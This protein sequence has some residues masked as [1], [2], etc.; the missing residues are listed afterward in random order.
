MDI[1][2]KAPATTIC[3]EPNLRAGQQL[4]EAC[5]YAQSTNIHT[6]VV[7]LRA[8]P[9]GVLHLHQRSGNFAGSKGQSKIP[10]T[11]LAFGCRPTAILLY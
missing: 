7:Y 4:V 6:T 9:V 5:F 11:S 1:G 3:E 8:V 2:S 10:L